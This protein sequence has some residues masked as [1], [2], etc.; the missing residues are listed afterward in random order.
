VFQK[1]IRGPFDKLFILLHSQRRTEAC[2]KQMI[3][4][5]ATGGTACPRTAAPP[6][7][8]RDL[9][10]GAKACGLPAGCGQEWPALSGTHSTSAR[11]RVGAAP[12]SVL[13]SGRYPSEKNRTSGPRGLIL[14][15]TAEAVPFVLSFS[16]ACLGRHI[17]KRLNV[18]VK[19]GNLAIV[20]H[21]Q[22]AI[23]AFA[24]LKEGLE[25]HR[26]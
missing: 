17:F 16:A 26:I 4:E 25:K 20:W 14:C 11:K 13:P 19:V 24:C 3:L 15:G 21:W 5:S 23:I 12:I 9:A 1:A 7:Q 8:P 2:Q 6:S 22:F 18:S 10:S